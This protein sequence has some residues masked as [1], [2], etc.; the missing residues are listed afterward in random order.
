MA[1]TGANPERAAAPFRR[2]I[3]LAFPRRRRTANP[4]GWEEYDG[5]PYT[6]ER[7]YGWLA[8]LR[9]A[10][11]DRGAH[12]RIRLPDG[13][14]TSP[15]GLG[16]PELASWQG[17]HP[18]NGLLVF[19]IDAPDGWY[20][21]GCTSVDPD[22]TLPLV[23]RRSVKFRA[24]DVVFA[25]A[26]FGAPLTVEGNRLVE[27]T[28]IVEITDGHLR[29]VVGDPAYGGWTWA[30]PGRW[31]VGWKSWRSYWRYTR[32]WRQLL[33][34]TVDPGF[35]S[36]RANSIEI[37]AV[38]AP[39][40]T[41]T[42]LY[43][44][45]FN[46][47]D[48]GDLDSGRAGDDGWTHTSLRPSI[49]GRLGCSLSSSSITLA[50]STAQPASA[51]LWQRVVGP[52]AGVVRYSTR[53]SLC[54]GE[55]RKPHR[56]SQEAGLLLLGDPRHPSEV[57][58]TFVG[59]LLDGDATGSGG[60]VTYRVGNGNG[61]YRTDV[62]IPETSLP[63]PLSEGEHEIVVEHDA[64]AGAL[65]SVRV[66]DVEIGG[67]LPPGSLVQE[68]SAGLFGVGGAMVPGRSGVALRQHFW[69]YKV[70]SLPSRNRPG[71]ARS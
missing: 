48:A 16:R 37:E 18:D 39:E 47:D 49:A 61:G 19:R 12:G 27:G 25:G 29:I 60:S 45:Y 62:G 36:L 35:H 41:A 52:S 64:D 26:R 4:P 33:T 69:Y 63:F 46:R 50:A 68:R 15:D 24:H 56:G 5:A 10:G 11:V 3:N 30:H 32:G 1:E 70:E 13:T 43:Q 31:S 21:V 57:S 17:T 22:V 8:D 9:D 28:G 54:M 40:A 51:A 71:G 66:N 58:G 67:Q 23:D 44:D 14:V 6:R 20:R 59:I 34:A 42:V 2:R 38:P 65:T 7:G 55:G 53:V